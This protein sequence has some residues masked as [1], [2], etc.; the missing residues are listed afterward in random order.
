MKKMSISELKKSYGG[1][2]TRRTKCVA[3][4]CGRIFKGKYVLLTWYSAKEQA[5]DHCYAWGGPS[6]GHRWVYID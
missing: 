2:D 5:V 4:G 6:E 3:S 1:K